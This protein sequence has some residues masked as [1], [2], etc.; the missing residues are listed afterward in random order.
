M[1]FAQNE[2]YSISLKKDVHITASVGRKRSTTA[3]IRKG[4]TKL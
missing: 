3:K 2:V 4:Y 1:V